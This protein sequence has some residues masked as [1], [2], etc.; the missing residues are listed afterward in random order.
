MLSYLYFGICKYFYFV[1]LVPLLLSPSHHVPREYL[2]PFDI[3]YI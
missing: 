1:I 3:C 2:T